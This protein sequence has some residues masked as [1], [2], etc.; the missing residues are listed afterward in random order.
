MC[1]P[2]DAP[3]DVRGAVLW[4]LRAWGYGAVQG[5]RGC[6]ALLSRDS[7]VTA[8]ATWAVAVWPVHRGGDFTPPTLF[9]KV[10]E[11]KIYSRVR[12]AYIKQ[13]FYYVAA[14]SS[15]HG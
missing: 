7:V 5:G 12:R 13:L 2:T 4:E 9:V 10:I 14:R 6:S 1:P 11:M 3:E 15:Q 8:V